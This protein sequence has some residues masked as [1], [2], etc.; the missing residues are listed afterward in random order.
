MSLFRGTSDLMTVMSPENT[1]TYLVALS[2]F[3]IL[4][5]VFNN[6]HPHRSPLYT[7]WSLLGSLV[8]QVGQKA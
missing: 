3:I 8:V 4:A 6:G 7:N 1:I 2:Q 5:L